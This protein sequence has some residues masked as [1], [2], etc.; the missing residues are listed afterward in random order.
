MTANR[1]A[2]ITAGCLWLA[3]EPCQAIVVRWEVASSS[4]ELL[5][6]QEAFS[7]LAKITVG[8]ACCGSTGSGY[9][10]NSEWLLSAA[11]VVYVQDSSSIRIDWGTESNTVREMVFTDEWQASP[12]TGL[13]QGGDLVLIHLTRPFEFDRQA[14]LASGSLDDRFAVMLG[15]GKGGN[16]VLGAYD[17]NLARAATNTIDRQLQTSGG[18]GLL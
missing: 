17:I 4:Y 8:S 13:E 9:L 7:G 3:G 2:W 15:T 1:C 12:E 18:G 10:L 16:G 11:H 14:Q 6:A 5:A